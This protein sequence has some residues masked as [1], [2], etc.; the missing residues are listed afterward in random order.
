MGYFIE[1]SF[2]IIK[3]SNFLK[4]KETIVNLAKKHNIDFFILGEVNSS[5]NL[6]IKNVTT[7]S[8]NDIKDLYE[9]TLTSIMC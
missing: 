5:S 6:N 2:D 8:I 4:V 7:I 1:T 9:N 3:T